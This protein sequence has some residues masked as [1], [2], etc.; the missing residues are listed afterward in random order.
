MA[1]D[2]EKYG[3]ND[4]YAVKLTQNNP[5][6]KNGCTGYESYYADLL[7]YW[8]K[9]YNPTTTDYRNYFVGMPNPQK[10]EE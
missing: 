6:F 4:D 10:P 3:H 2:Y 9:I 5:E 8:R 1:L 7:A